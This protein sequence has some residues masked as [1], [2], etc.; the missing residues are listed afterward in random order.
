MT[1]R[2][3]GRKGTFS[4][5]EVFTNKAVTGVGH[6]PVKAPVQKDLVRFKGVA[7]GDDGMI[8][9]RPGEASE[10]PYGPCLCPQSLHL[11]ADSVP[12]VAEC[13]MSWH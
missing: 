8:V 7:G 3:Q 1:P 10:G 6:L 12:T 2:R 11:T 9:I 4:R 5:D 13:R